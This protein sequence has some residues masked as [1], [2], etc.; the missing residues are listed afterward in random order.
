ML[1]M[2]YLVYY[3]ILYKFV[4]KVRSIR[5]IHFKIPKHTAEVQQRNCV[6]AKNGRFQSFQSQVT[7]R[8]W[9]LELPS[10]KQTV[11]EAERHF[12]PSAVAQDRPVQGHQLSYEARLLRVRMQQAFYDGPFYQPH[13]KVRVIFDDSHSMTHFQLMGS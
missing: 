4:V 10:W 5:E 8:E 7:V 1:S 3:F 13:T 11:L 12:L 2:K 9:A 6:I